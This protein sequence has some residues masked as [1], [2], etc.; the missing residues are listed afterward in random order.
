MERKDLK[1]FRKTSKSFY[2]VVKQN[3]AYVDI[4]D[5]TIYLTVKE[6]S[7]DPDTSAV[8]QKDIISHI[9]P[10]QGKTL[11]ELTPNDLDI[12]ARNYWYDIVGKDGSGNVH[13]ISIGKLEI[14]EVITQRS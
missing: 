9:D 6:K 12:E 14:E 3:G 11:I 7:T 1:F 8:I 13:L 5:W 4:T 10:T 2:I